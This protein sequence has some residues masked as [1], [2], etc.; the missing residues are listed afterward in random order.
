ME[1]F[2]EE[3]SQKIWASGSFMRPSEFKKLLTEMRKQ[4]DQCNRYVT[5]IRY[6]DII[7]KDTYGTDEVYSKGGKVLW[8]GYCSDCSDCQRHKKLMKTNPIIGIHLYSEYQIPEKR[9]W[10]IFGKNK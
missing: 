10:K 1:Y 5:S 3:R 4:G 8:T 2:K 9:D 6:Y 7:D